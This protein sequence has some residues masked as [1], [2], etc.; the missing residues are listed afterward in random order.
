[1]EAQTLTEGKELNEVGCSWLYGTA[2]ALIV[3]TLFIAYPLARM[4]QKRKEG[5]DNDG[6]DGFDIPQRKKFKDE[7]GQACKYRPCDYRVW[8]TPI[9]SLPD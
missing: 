4:S 8:Q 1:M 7:L 2:D 6:L 3:T 9:V 5:D